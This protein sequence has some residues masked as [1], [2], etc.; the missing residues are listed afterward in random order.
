MSKGRCRYTQPI[1]IKAE[2]GLRDAAA[3]AARGQGLS[4]SEL[5]RRD[6]RAIVAARPDA[7]DQGQRAA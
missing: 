6:L 4:L 7:M 2:P 5:V 3:E 1:L